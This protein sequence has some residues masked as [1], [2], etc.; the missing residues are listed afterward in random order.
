MRTSPFICLGGVPRRYDSLGLLFGLTSYSKSSSSAANAA[1]RAF[2]SAFFAVDGDAVDDV[3][4]S[5][6]DGVSTAADDCS[7]ASFLIA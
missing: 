1:I 3:I 6:F 4:L 5:I 2:L 7:S